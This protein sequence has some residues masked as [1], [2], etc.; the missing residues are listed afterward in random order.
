MK[1][2]EQFRGTGQ[3]FKFTLVQLFKSKAN[4]I[5][6]IMMFVFSLASAPLTVLLSGSSGGTLRTLYID[7]QS[8][9][10]LT[11][12]QDELKDTDSL[13]RAV[14]KEGTLPEEEASAAGFTLTEEDDGLM[15]TMKVTKSS[16]IN[17]SL[18]YSAAEEFVH[19]LDI[20]KLKASG[21]DEESLAVLKK[22]VTSETISINDMDKAAD[23][24]EPDFNQTDY[25]MQMGYSIILMMCCIFSISYV[26]RSVIEEK[27]SKL[28]DLLLVSVKPAALLLGKVLAV[29][30]YV[31]FYMAVLVFGLMISSAVTSR[32]ADTGS[33][34]GFISALFALKP[35]FIDIVVILITSGLGYLAFGILAGLSGAGCSNI[36]EASGAMSTCMLLIMVGYFVSIMSFITGK[37]AN[38]A[39]CIAPIISMFMAPLKFMKGEISILIV[40]LSW[41]VQIICIYLLILLSGKVYSSLIIYKGKRLG[42][43]DILS[44]AGKKEGAQ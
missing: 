3:V 17:N 16:K 26:I 22:E 39:L 7:N 21:A 37:S 28:V 35:R 33:I 27:A 32:F 11:G 41:I 5:A 12:L 6:L 38:T 18:A 13:S 30:I 25:G 15:V 14:I 20:L 36:E 1:I 2:K 4:I 31:I 23:T 40:L 43:K 29:L 44:M 10:D 8:S 9:F 42:L 24:E 34:T 19:A